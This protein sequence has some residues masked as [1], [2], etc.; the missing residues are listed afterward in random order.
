[1]KLRGTYNYCRQ[2]NFTKYMEILNNEIKN[3]HLILEKK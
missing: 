1:M 3:R 2:K